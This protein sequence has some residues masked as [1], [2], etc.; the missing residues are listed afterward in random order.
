MFENLTIDRF[1]ETLTELKETVPD[2]H[3]K[4]IALVP[5]GICIQGVNP[6]ILYMYE[7]KSGCLYRAKEGNKEYELFKW[8][9]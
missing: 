9:D 6:D 1:M 2:L 3:I 4:M 8:R 5:D 7:S